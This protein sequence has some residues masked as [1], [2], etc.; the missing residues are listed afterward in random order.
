MDKW[1]KK[2]TT[3]PFLFLNLNNSSVKVME[4][5]VKIYLVTDLKHLEL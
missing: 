4:K 5:L 2:Q 3:P 1:I